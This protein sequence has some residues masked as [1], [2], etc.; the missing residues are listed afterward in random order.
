MSVVVWITRREGFMWGGTPMKCSFSDTGPTCFC[1]RVTFSS[2]ARQLSALISVTWVFHIVCEREVDVVWPWTCSFLPSVYGVYFRFLPRGSLVLALRI[3]TLQAVKI[4]IALPL[5][6]AIHQTCDQH[7]WVLFYYYYFIHRRAGG[8]CVGVYFWYC[9]WVVSYVLRDGIP[10]SVLSSIFNF[11][12][13]FYREVLTIF[14][15]FH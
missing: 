6:L 8:A 9:Q 10:H 13:A 14:V 12:I 11:V 3:G 2:E 15:Y 4:C 5:C 1:G 7:G